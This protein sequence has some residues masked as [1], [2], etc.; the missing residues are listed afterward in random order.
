MN[1]EYDL[2]GEPRLRAIVEQH[3]ELPSDQLRER[4]VRE[5]EAFVARRIR[6]TT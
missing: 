6:T 4:I 2:F 3:G 5:V 1:L